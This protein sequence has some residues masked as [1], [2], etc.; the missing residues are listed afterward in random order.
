MK[1]IYLP[2]N[3]LPIPEGATIEG[4]EIEIDEASLPIQEHD[5]RHVRIVNSETPSSTEG[6]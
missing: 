4:I 1:P 2:L 6:I 5:F 3:K